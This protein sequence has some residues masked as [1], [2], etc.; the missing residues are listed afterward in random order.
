MGLNTMS[1]LWETRT[2]SIFL[3]VLILMLI[4]LCLKVV[5]CSRIE[6]DDE[7]RRGGGGGNIFNKKTRKLLLKLFRR[8]IKIPEKSSLSLATQVSRPNIAP[9][10][11]NQEDGIIIDAVVEFPMWCKCIL[12]FCT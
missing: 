7:G 11:F 3:L 1:S 12:I 9:G 6:E 5:V 10:I 2:K 4:I 8:R